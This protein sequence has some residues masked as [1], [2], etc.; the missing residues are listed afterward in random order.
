MIG[1]SASVLIARIRLADLQPTMCWIAPLMPHAMYRSGAMRCPVWPTCCVCG[2]QPLLV[3][4]R[5]TPMA[6]PSNSASSSSSENAAAEPTP[7]PPPTTTFASVSEIEP[8]V[9]G[10]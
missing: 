7:R 9:G 6:A 2:R 10:S 3:T 4:T 5:D 8:F 1:D